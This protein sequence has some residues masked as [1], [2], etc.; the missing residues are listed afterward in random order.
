M[1]I[2]VLEKFIV[3]GVIFEAGEV[4]VVSD[5]AGAEYCSL[6]WAS[7]V[8]GNVATQERK[9]GAQTLVPEKV[10]QLANGGLL[11]E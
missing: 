5:E 4:R 11:Q 1:K 9:P 7:D 8:D 6:G 2:E 10:V 3:D